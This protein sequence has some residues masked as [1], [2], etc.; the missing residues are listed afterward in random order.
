MLLGSA[1]VLG[2]LELG[3]APQRWQAGCAVTLA[4]V[5]IA[6]SL[7]ATNADALLQLGVPDGIRGRM[8]ALYAYAWLGTSALSALI[9]PEGMRPVRVRVRPPGIKARSGGSY[10][11]R[12]CTSESVRSEPMN[13]TRNG[14]PGRLR[15]MSAAAG[16]LALSSLMLVAGAAPSSAAPAPTRALAA[17][18]TPAAAAVGLPDIS[19]PGSG[20]QLPDEY[21]PYGQHCDRQD[22]SANIFTHYFYN[23]DEGMDIHVFQEVYY[24]QSVVPNPVFPDPPAVSW[25]W[26]YA[27]C[28]H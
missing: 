22:F 11:R 18:S 3:V 24:A 7:F 19:P 26:A 14:L 15:R 25:W 5:G 8:L 4:L 10:V 23:H 13:T 20:T 9:Q 2:L 27:R 21:F 17:A 12:K 28:P 1:G 16:A 6:F